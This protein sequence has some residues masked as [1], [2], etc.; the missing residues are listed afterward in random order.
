MGTKAFGEQQQA[1]A[2]SGGWLFPHPVFGQC[3]VWFPLLL[4]MTTHKQMLTECL[5]A[6]EQVFVGQDIVPELGH[7]AECDSIAK[8]VAVPG[9]GRSWG[10][11]STYR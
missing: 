10:K 5:Y 11:L 9:G 3:V 6:L 7:I 4:F 2:V 1:W 8:E